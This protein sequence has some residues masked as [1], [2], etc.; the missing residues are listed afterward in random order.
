[1]PV[2]DKLARLG[3]GTGKTQTID[4]GIESLLEEE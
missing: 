2:A 4:D 3:A 1:M